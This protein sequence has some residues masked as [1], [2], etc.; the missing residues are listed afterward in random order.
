MVRVT[1]V[2]VRSCVAL[3]S[4]GVALAADLAL[5]N[6][7]FEQADGERPL[8]WSWWSRE[9]G[10][11]ATVAPGEGRNGGQ[12]ALLRHDGERDWAFSS[13]TR[14]PAQP[15]QEF[16]VRGWVRGEQVAGVE[17]AVVALSG[18]KTL[19]WNIGGDAA[20]A[21]PDWAELVGAVR[22]PQECDAIYVRFVG[23][24]R[25]RAYVDDVSLSEGAPPRPIKPKVTGWATERATEALDRGLVAVPAGPGQVYVGWRLLADDPDDIAFELHRSEAGAEPVKLNGDPITATTDFLDEGL[26]LGTEYTYS[27]HVTGG[28]AGRRGLRLVASAACVARDEARPY[29]AVKLVGEHDFQK[30][31]I[32]DLDGDGRYD[33]VLKQPNRNVDPYVQY[34]ERSPGTYTLEAY[35]ADGEPLWH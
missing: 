1:T 20:G 6:P 13:R 31:G 19:S 8:G 34:W 29:V 25:T 27:L 18:D 24:G 26:T 22:V 3:L 23:Q 17:L 9:G 16:T 33:Y 11:S 5:G 32:G 21:A 4:C 2:L 30:V 10:G 12:C 15:G 28:V 35:T 7:S 14:F